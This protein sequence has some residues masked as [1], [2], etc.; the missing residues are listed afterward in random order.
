VIAVC[1]MVLMA[2]SAWGFTKYY[3]S[4]LGPVNAKSSQTITVKIPSGA[5]LSDIGRLLE[6]N[7]LVKKAWAFNFYARWNHLNQYRSGTYHLNRKM[8]VGKIMALLENGEHQQL[9]LL[10][11]VRQ[12]MWV[13]EVA[14][15]MSRVSGINRQQILSD[16][17]SRTY[18]RTHYMSRYSF[19]T[20]EILTK[21][22]DYPLEGYLAPGAY[23]FDKG[24]KL[25]LDQMVDPMLIQTGKELKQNAAAIKN[26]QLGSAHKVLT[27]ASLVE[28]EAPDLKNREKIA[29]VFYNRLKINMRLQSDTTVIYGRQ[30]RDLNYTIKDIHHDTVY[31]T[32]TRSGLPAGPIGSP[33]LDAINA[34]LHSVKSS[35]LFFYARPNGKVYYSKT[36]AEHQKI[37]QKYSHE[38]ASK[39]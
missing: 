9:V 3:E 37:I 20:N 17:S 39:S 16:L 24:K 22:I 31:N 1:L 38:W 18:I 28:A 33:A 5:S 19:L 27:M 14:D 32:Y 15:Q 23:R 7:G 25:T 2:L 11:D 10:I 12:G 35:N 30:K 36:Y 8:S 34:V 29:G 13:S 4:L 6:K 21:G 26:N